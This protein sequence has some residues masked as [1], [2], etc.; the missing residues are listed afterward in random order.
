M[1]RIKTLV[2]ACV[3]RVTIT[4]L[5]SRILKKINFNL[6]IARTLRVGDCD[7]KIQIIVYHTGA[8][9]EARFLKLICLPRPVTELLAS[10]TAKMWYQKHSEAPLEIFRRF[11]LALLPMEH[12]ANLLYHL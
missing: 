1:L 11:H 6:R 12:R 3:L 2:N 7:K 8:R 5:T 10:H 9:F 4:I